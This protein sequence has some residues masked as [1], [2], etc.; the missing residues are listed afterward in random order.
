MYDRYLL[1]IPCS[2]RKASLPKVRVPAIDLYDG[3][4]YRIIRKAFREHG[5]PD[6]LDIMILSAKYGLIGPDEEIATYDQ[7][8]TWEMAKGM[9]G[10][11]YT[12][13]AN[14]L[15]TNQYEEVMINLGKQYTIAL[16]ESQ[17][18][19]AD[20]KVRYANG[21]IGERIKQLKE[22]LS[23]VYQDR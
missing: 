19:L 18:V 5:K 20:Q 13:L 21:R 6:N 14:T 4:F 3:P 22:W 17:D 2:K 1:I 23:N 7:R 10:S 16:S 12:S 11:V 15:K 8:M 9:S